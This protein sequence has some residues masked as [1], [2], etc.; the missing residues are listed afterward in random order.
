MHA[1]GHRQGR[2]DRQGLRRGIDRARKDRLKKAA[3]RHRR[4]MKLW[5]ARKE[6][7]KLYST[8]CLPSISYGMEVTGAHAT[9][10][11]R[12]RGDMASCGVA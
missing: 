10:S 9:V 7:R 1:G 4:I 12:A 2:T 3:L 5:R 11:K 8:G 6:A